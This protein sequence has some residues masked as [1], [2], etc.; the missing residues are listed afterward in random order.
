MAQ[1]RTFDPLT[2]EFIG[3]STT[4]LTCK[5]KVSDLATGDYFLEKDKIYLI[6]EHRNVSGSKHWVAYTSLVGYEIFEGIPLNTKYS[7]Q[8]MAVIAIPTVR[9]VELI[10]IS[11]TDEVSYIENDGSNKEDLNLLLVKQDVWG[12]ALKSAFQD[13]RS[14]FLSVVRVMGREKIVGFRVEN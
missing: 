11:E 2:S 14:I 9:E 13:H 10:D 3:D 8:Y 5:L 12:K 1:N 4:G 7:Q 6:T